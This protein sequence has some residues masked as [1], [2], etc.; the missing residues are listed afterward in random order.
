MIELQLGA[1]V[2]MM[3]DTRYT[4]TRRS[5]SAHEVLHITRAHFGHILYIV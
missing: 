5:G 2:V 3:R 1:T 4:E